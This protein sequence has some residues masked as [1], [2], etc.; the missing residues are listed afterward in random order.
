MHTTN[1]LRLLGLVVPLLVAMLASCEK[2][3]CEQTWTQV[4]PVPVTLNRSEVHDSI[5]AM[6]PREFCTGGNLYAYGQYVFVNVNREGYHLL[7]NSNP[8]NP[9]PVAFLRVPGATH[10]AFVDGRMVSDSYADLLVLDFGGPTDLALVS[11]TPNL[12]LQTDAFEVGEDAVAVGFEDRA[13]EFT[14]SCSG[15]VTGTWFGRGF[16]EDVAFNALSAD[17]FRGGGS[18]PTVNTAGSLARLAFCDS[19][20]YALSTDRLSAFDLVDDG[21][22]ARETTQLGWGQ[23]TIIRRGDHLYVASRSALRIFDIAGCGDP[24]E[25]GSAPHRWAWDPVAVE[26]NRAVV[27]TRWGEGTDALGGEMI[28]FDVADPANPIRLATHPLTQ[29][30]GLALHGGTLYVCDAVDGLR[31]YDFAGGGAESLTERELAGFPER[32]VLDVA[33]LPYPAGAVLLGVGD[34]EL[35]QFAVGD[36]GELETLV[37]LDVATCARS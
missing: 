19:R 13:V 6:P 23:E 15:R 28:V 18:T 17:A 7:D 14:Q 11:W 27:T 34:D 1:P 33:V 35:S 37:T 32:R 31:V 10:M 4:V 3:S 20:L 36:G 2:D 29:P 21:L 26:G 5:A 24:R 16:G 12:L 25:L 8:A 22:E 30:V 9:T